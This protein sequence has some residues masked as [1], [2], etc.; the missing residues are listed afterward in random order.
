LILPILLLLSFLPASHEIAVGVTVA[1]FTVS[2]G[3]GVFQLPPQ[4]TT[5]QIGIVT[6]CLECNIKTTLLTVLNQN[7]F[8]NASWLV[9]NP[10]S[11]LPANHTMII[12][13]DAS[14]VLVTADV[15]VTGTQIG[16]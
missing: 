11:L 14:N 1:T 5:Y 13:W 4:N 15:T 16:V 12:I 2:N 8:G 3:S 6:A 9:I 10:S 7:D